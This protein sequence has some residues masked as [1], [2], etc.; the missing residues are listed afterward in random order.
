MRCSY[1]NGPGDPGV[2]DRQVGVVRDLLGKKPVFGIC[3]G[4]QLI[5]RALGAKTFKM[6]FGH[7]GI[8]HPVRDE[9][10]G[11]VLVTSQ[12]HGFAVDESTLP[13][14]VGSLV[15]ERERRFERRNTPSPLPAALRSVPS[16]VGAGAAGFPL[17]FPVVPGSRSRIRRRQCGRTEEGAFMPARKDIASILIIGSGPI[18]I[19]QACEFDYSGTQAVNALKEEGYTVILVNPNPATVMTTPN[20]ADRIYMEPLKAPYVEEI[21]RPERPDAVLPTM[22]GQT[23]ST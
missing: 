12:N 10:T 5:A 8:N 18:V 20:L 9:S 15:P 23:G 4:H 17:D 11:R 21:I 7:H 19:G 13:E 6:K 16:R 1:S 2:L 14:D 22:G 3:L